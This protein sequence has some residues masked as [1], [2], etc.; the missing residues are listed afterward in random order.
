[1][2]RIEWLK[3]ITMMVIMMFMV[4]ACSEGGSNDE[5]PQNP[6]TPQKPDT[7]V[8]NGDWQVVPVGGGTIQKDD[9]TIDFPSGT[10]TKDVK[11]AI[12]EMKKGEVGHEYEASKFYKVTMPATTYK[13]LTIRMKCDKRDNDIN[14]VIYS[15]GYAI[16]SQKETQV[17]CYPET[18]YT[19]GEYK[20][21][22]PICDNGET[23][24]TLNF[25]I[26]LGHIPTLN[27]TK[28]LCTRAL[29]WTIDSDSVD[30]VNWDIY[31]SWDTWYNY[32]RA[33]LNSLKAF[34]KT[35]NSC[36]K[37]AVQQIH[38]LGFKLKSQRTIPFYFGYYKDR[39]FWGLH[40]EDWMNHNWSCIYLNVSKIIGANFVMTTE[41]KQTVIHETLHYYH[42]DYDPRYFSFFKWGDSEYVALSEMGAVW[43]EKFMDGGRPNPSFHYEGHGV[44]ATKKTR[45]R[46][47]LSKA[48]SDVKK[49]FEKSG[50]PIYQEYGYSLAPLLYY[51]TTRK[52]DLAITDSNVVEIY[53]RWNNSDYIIDMLHFWT[54]LHFWDFFSGNKIDDYYL[55]LWKGE[56]IKGLNY[57]SV[58]DRA[59]NEEV[60][61][62]NIIGKGKIS[63]GEVFPFGCEGIDGEIAGFKDITMADKE[64]V[65]KQEAAN[66]QTY[67]LLADATLVESMTSIRQYPKVAVGQGD[68]IVISGEELEKLRKK[69]G[70][71]DTGFLLLNTRTSSKITDTGSIPTKTSIELRE[72]K[73]TATINPSKLTFLAG[74]GTK[75]AN[76]DGYDF[77][78]IGF[79]TPPSWLKV[80][81][82]DK[83]KSILFTAVT[84]TT[85]KER[86]D[87]VKCYV[88]NV[89]KPTNKDKKYLPVIV[90]QKASP[91]VNPISLT[92]EAEGG[93]QTLKCNYEGYKY[94]GCIISE[95]DKSWLSRTFVDGTYE[96]TAEP[97]MTGKER[98]T[99]IRCYFANVQNSS[100]S[101]RIY[102]D[103]K[104]AQKA[105]DIPT[106]SPTSLTYDAEG[107]MQTV[108]IKVQGWKYCGCIIDDDAKSWLSKNYV[109][110][111][112]YEVTAEPNTTS[113]E[114]TT[115]IRC[116]VANEKNA[117]DDK[118]IYME[119]Q[120]AQMAGKEQTGYGNYEF[121]EGSFELNVRVN[122][123]SHA[124][125]S[126]GS[127]YLKATDK[128]LAVTPNGK[129][130][131][132]EF[133]IDIN[134]KGYS[135][136]IKGQFDIDDLTL[137]DSQKSSVTNISWQRE[138][139]NTGG[140]SWGGTWGWD[141]MILSQTQKMHFSTN[142]KIPQTS[143][144]YGGENVMWYAGLDE[145]EPT[146][147]SF[148]RTSI[149]DAGDGKTEPYVETATELIGDS[150][151]NVYLHFKNKAESR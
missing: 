145:F 1:M 2:R 129:G 127:V 117:P 114:R 47:G 50:D 38:K 55:K 135:E 43:I 86:T 63:P 105:N 16:S 44:G 93:M 113:K 102:V 73:P 64:L 151:I 120:V 141:G 108:Q 4:T 139:Y 78:H 111:G 10:F 94:S 6:P 51:L 82:D 61:F 5:K 35:L 49:M 85:D 144:E 27:N 41:L 48:K 36:I 84:N 52:G 66:V 83:D 7:P 54:L 103:V 69:S 115:T 75:S 40:S 17:E 104:V 121:V 67:L 37:D 92:F 100:E 131:H 29:N 77:K 150:S 88:T 112:L 28:S 107:G 91:S 31:I 24:E 99:T 45:F 128:Y 89:D 96:V 95:A 132:F 138:T 15:P 57:L 80:K 21:F 106:V 65:I 70:E 20:T 81:V 134:E 25:T 12:V 58:R 122:T 130:L 8:S 136:K 74:G 87:T 30:N 14:F 56:L 149:L 72:V 116:Y 22:I 19:N 142:S 133:N 11:V 123:W 26:G 101:E 39:D 18:S 119:V 79:D 148:V 71:F 124:W 140:W 76:V 13:A 68:S 3:Y 32:D 98:S 60:L 33:T 90:T 110:G 147:Y 46:L 126:M 146:G 34:S 109:S 137:M 125:D 42:S 59:I 143:F 97:N 53:D 118:R 62:K 9:I 23:D